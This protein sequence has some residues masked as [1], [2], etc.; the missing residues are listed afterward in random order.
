MPLCASSGKWNGFSRRNCA[1][2]VNKGS[3]YSK[4]ACSVWDR[5]I[6]RVR[7]GRICFVYT[8]SV[9]VPGRFSTILSKNFKSKRLSAASTVPSWLQSPFAFAIELNETTPAQYLFSKT[10][11]QR[12][13]LL[14]ILM[15]PQGIL[16]ISGVVLLVAVFS[17]VV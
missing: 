11:S 7:K 8:V 1:G 5:R 3:V 6:F 2:K 15:S 10:A 4:S 13:I 14:S 17:V 9:L 16:S 12:S